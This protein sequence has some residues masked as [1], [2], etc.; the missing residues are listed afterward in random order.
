MKR[1]ISRIIILIIVCVC[2]GAYATPAWAWGQEGH[3]IIAKIAYDHM[4]RKARKSVDRIMGQRGIIYWANWP[5]EIKSDTIYAQ[6]IKDGWHY[7]DLE[8]G[9]S[10]SLVMDALVHYRSV[11]GNLFRALDSLKA[12]MRDVETSRLRDLERA[13]RVQTEHVLRFIVHLSGDRY[14][15][16]HLAH[17]DDKGGNAVKM[18]WFGRNTNLHSVWD[19]KLIES[20][21]YSYTEYAQMIEDEFGWKR[22]AIEQATDEELLRQ[23]YHMVEDIYR[24]QETWDENTYHYIYRWHKDCEEQLYI[25]G[26]R[27]AKLL[28]AIFK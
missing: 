28:N 2:A 12:I 26:I 7:Q 24:Y 25:A 13:K 5:D 22:K 19:T 15:P 16:M 14:C 21:G 1:R 27:L 20:Q 8:S 9:L 4:S 18:Q 10:D 11:G 6:S 3:R 23:S 17:M